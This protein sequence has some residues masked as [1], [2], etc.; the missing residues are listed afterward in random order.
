M[1]QEN[2]G[3]EQPKGDFDKFKEKQKIKKERHEKHSGSNLNDLSQEKD[4]QG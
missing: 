4:K 2:G 3:K 1:Q